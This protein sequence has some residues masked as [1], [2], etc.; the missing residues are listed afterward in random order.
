VRTYLLFFCFTLLMFGGAP[1]VAHAGEDPQ[2]TQARQHYQK[3]QKAYD[4]GHWDQAIKEFEAAY[5]LRSDPNFLYNMAQAYRR[6]GDTQRSL[7]LFKNFLSKVPGTPM[8]ADIEARIAALKEQLE[9]EREAERK[10]AA[11]VESTT[12]P[13]AP[14]A[15]PVPPPPSPEATEVPA[16]TE[17]AP[18]SPVDPGIASPALATTPTTATPGNRPLRIT[19]LVVGGAGLAGMITG[20]AMGIRAKSLSDE[21]T[22]DAKKGTYAQSKVDSGRL[23]ETLQWVGYGIGVAALAGGSI[24]YW[25]G[26]PK[27]DAP[28]A[29][30]SLTVLPYVGKDGVGS[31]LVVGF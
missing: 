22:A 27:S 11:E 16:T 26:L 5:S 9:Q 24:L 29:Q 15:T 8:R 10:A 14:L 18:L 17:P 6:K 7:D 23:A 4:L 28:A 25:L 21:V 2:T 31:H 19:G 30:P 1:M 13:P 20:V 3:A 12:P